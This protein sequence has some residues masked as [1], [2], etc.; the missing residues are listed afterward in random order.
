[1]KN[2]NT[3][4]SVS[5][6]IVVIL[7]ISSI[8]L[9]GFNITKNKT[10]NDYYAVYLNGEKIGTP[11]IKINKSGLEDREAWHLCWPRAVRSDAY[12]RRPRAGDRNL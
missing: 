5:L 1:M 6:M 4:L 3:N 11:F 2:K 7:S 12:D 10:P 8:F 9:L